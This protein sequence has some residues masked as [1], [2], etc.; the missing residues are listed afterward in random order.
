MKRVYAGVL[1]DDNGGLTPLGK[2][3]MDAW[4][5]G[6]VPEEDDCAGWDLGRV[7]QVYDQVYQ[8][9]QPYGHL[10]SRLPEEL[11]ERHKRIYDAAVERARGVGWSP[12][13]EF[14]EE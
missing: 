6:L 2:V 14:G 8:A 4:V 12:E 9:W 10:P 5:F 1:N 11:L 13:K 3:V 7:Q